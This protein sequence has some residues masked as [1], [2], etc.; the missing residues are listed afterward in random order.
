MWPAEVRFRTRTAER[1]FDALRALVDGLDVLPTTA[2]LPMRILELH[3]DPSSTLEQFGEAL[4]ADPSLATRVLGLANSAWAAQG[5]R[6]TR[7]SEAI[8]LIGVNNLMPLL[9]GVS[10]AGLF[11][12][13]DVPPSQREELWRTALL[14][15]VV[16]RSTAEA[17]QT[18]L[19]E[20]A[21][22][23]GLIQDVGMGV[24]LACDRA[25]AVELNV[26]FGL[27]PAVALPRERELFG[28]THGDVARAIALR[29]GLPELYVE[30]AR[31]HHDTQG[32]RFP[33]GFESLATAVR[34]S[35]GVPHRPQPSAPPVGEHF[36][37]CLRDIDPELHK[38]SSD[39]VAGLMKQYCGLLNALGSAPSTSGKPRTTDD[40]QLTFRTFLQEVCQ[41]VAATLNGAIEHSVST[42]TQLQQRVAELEAREAAADVDPLTGLL[43]RAAFVA[44]GKRLLELA[45]ENGWQVAVGLAD[46]D[47]FGK[48]NAAHGKDVADAALRALARVLKECVGPAGAVGRIDGDE[49]GFVLVNE[50]P[51]QLQSIGDDLAR[52]LS[53]QECR[54]GTRSFPLG[55]TGGIVTVGVPSATVATFES[56]LAGARALMTQGKASGKN[57]CVREP[58]TPVAAAA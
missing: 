37:R 16:A 18:A 34:L 41:R 17:Q 30:V 35:A 21:F 32:P 33:S 20:E 9:F 25:A 3:R 13:A 47:D 23:T 29:L 26:I 39:F 36:H 42:V 11:N 5:K 4:M 57:R 54:V 28:V 1:R 52:A 31:G 27:D 22:L 46:V 53:L 24:M 48:V 58:P 6:V 10:L 55:C 49:F 19:V 8:R 43:H 51:Q 44:R 40:A 15:A 50:T 38:Q 56:H 2:R 14:K 12:R 45:G 7:V